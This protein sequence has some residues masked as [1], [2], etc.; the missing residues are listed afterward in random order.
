MTAPRSSKDAHGRELFFT[1]LATRHGL[2]NR[3]RKVSSL[4]VVASRL[5]F[6]PGQARSR[7]PAYRVQRTADHAFR[8]PG[9]PLGADR[10]NTPGLADGDT[11]EKGD[12]LAVMEAMKMETQ[13]TAARRGTFRIVVET[14]SHL[15]AGASLGRYEE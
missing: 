10:W 13:V 14:G 5:P 2:P 11:V 9:R 8:R 6:R 1:S 12:L 4:L 15:E 7:S 3:R